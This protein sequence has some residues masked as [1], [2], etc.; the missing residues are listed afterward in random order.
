MSG[1]LAVVLVTVAIAVALWPRHCFVMAQVTSGSR[2]RIVH[3]CSSLSGFEWS[4]SALVAMGIVLGPALL[5]ILVTF[6]VWRR[7]GRSA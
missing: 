5:L 2:G 1:L 6:L 3:S 7:W 4:H